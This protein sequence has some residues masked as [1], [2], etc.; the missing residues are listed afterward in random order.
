MCRLAV[1]VLSPLAVSSSYS[2]DLAREEALEAERGERRSLQ[3]AVLDGS[4][5]PLPGPDLPPSEN[6]QP[7]LNEPCYTHGDM[8]N[9]CE[10]DT[11]LSQPC[12]GEKR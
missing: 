10:L 8:C 11:P 4:M 3:T 7:P 1:A 9:G 2:A 12:L 6:G 5:L